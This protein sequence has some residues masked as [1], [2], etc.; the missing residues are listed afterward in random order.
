VLRLVERHLEGDHR[1]RGMARD[2]S[3]IDAQVAQQRCAMIRVVGDRHLARRAAAPRIARSV[4]HEDA[5]PVGERRLSSQRREEVGTDAGV[6]EHHHIAGAAD[7]V[8]ELYVVE[9]RTKPHRDL[10]SDPRRPTNALAAARARTTPFGVQIHI[11]Y[12]RPGRV[13]F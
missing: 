1:A 3:P 11:Q 12:A 6:N 2:V 9:A 8:L 7:V 13:R 10:L 4:V 5:M